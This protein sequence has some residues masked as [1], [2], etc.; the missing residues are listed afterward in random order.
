MDKRQPE[1]TLA[2]YR[3]TYDENDCSEW[4][5]ARKELIIELMDED[6]SPTCNQEVKS[7]ALKEVVHRTI[8][9]QTQ[10]D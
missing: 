10:A 7:T 1:K 2:L 5:N 6:L 9:T 4:T 8:G 3:D